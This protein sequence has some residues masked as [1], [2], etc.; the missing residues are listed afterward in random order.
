[1]SRDEGDS[2]SA[3]DGDPEVVQVEPPAVE[4]ATDAVEEELE[5]EADEG[6]ADEGFPSLHLSRF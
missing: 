2:S 5:D 3:S 6:E 1:M 4:D